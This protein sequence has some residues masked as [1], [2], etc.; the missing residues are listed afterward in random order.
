MV[1]IP[2]RLDLLIGPERVASFLAEIR[3]QQPMVVRARDMGG[4]ERFAGVLSFAHMDALLCSSGLR[5]P[6]VQVRRAGS[7]VPPSEWSLPVLAWGPG[8]VGRFARPERLLELLRGGCSLVLDDVGRIC[9]SVAQV[10]AGL[11]G[12][13]GGEA[14]ARAVL[15]PAEGAWSAPRYDTHEHFI[16]QCGGAARWRVYPAARCQP[17]RDEPCR[18]PLLSPGEPL[19]ETRLE[20]G[21]LLYIPRGFAHAAAGEPGARSLHVEGCVV[22]TTWWDVV[23]A[24]AAHLDH[25]AGLPGDHA[26]RVDTRSAVHLSEPREDWLDEQVEDTLCDLPIGDVVATWLAAKRGPAPGGPTLSSALG[27]D[28]G[29]QP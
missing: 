18:E 7:P 24:A 23:Q 8:Q 1:P 12:A 20:A 15:A 9:P 27:L 14:F 2:T 4:P 5:G 3:D 26:V 11:H 13:L 19:L 28:D 16:L 29:G 6:M 25:T 17:L 10:V 21:D 22:P